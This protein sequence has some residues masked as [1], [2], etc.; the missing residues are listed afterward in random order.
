MLETRAADAR[1][2]AI[3]HFD[4]QLASAETWAQFLAY[5]RLRNE[6]DFPGEPL[7]SDAHAEQ[8][9][10]QHTPLH[11]VHRVLAEDAQGRIVG[12]VNMA[13]AAK[14]R[15]T[16]KPMRPS[17]MSRAACGNRIGGKA[18]AASCC[19]NCWR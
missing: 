3:S 1:P 7:P 18:S 8:N 11:V 14:A 17:S 16:T 9:V 6:E 2:F 19:G 15:P 12:N 5:W 4:P 13:F 10:R